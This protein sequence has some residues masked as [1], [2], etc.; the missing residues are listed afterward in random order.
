VGCAFFAFFHNIEY[1]KAIGGHV[2]KMGFVCLLVLAFLAFSAAPGAVHAGGGGGCGD[3]EGC[4]NTMYGIAIGAALALV[5]YLLY[6]KSHENDQNTKS[7]K[8]DQE[9]SSIQLQ[10][11]NKDEVTPKFAVYRW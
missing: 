2:M 8:E 10:N 11:P 9:L 1:E 6:Q 4:N 3:S 5:I 7:D